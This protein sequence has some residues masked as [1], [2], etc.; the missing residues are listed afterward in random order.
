MSPYYFGDKLELSKADIA[1]AKALMATK[2]N[3]SA[4][5]SRSAEKV[6]RQT[7]VLV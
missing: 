5:V 1:A 7:R 6:R 2:S 3:V 4:A